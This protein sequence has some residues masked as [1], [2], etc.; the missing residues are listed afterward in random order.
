MTGAAPLLQVRGLARRYGAQSVFENVHLEVH[1]GEFVAI[2]G[3]SGVG[4]ST[5]LNCLAGLDRWDAGQGH[6]LQL[7]AAELLRQPFRQA[8]QPHGGQHGL[9]ARGVVASQQHQRQR[10]VLR[11]VQVRQ[12]MEGL[13]DEAHLRAPPQGALGIVQRAEV[14]AAVH[15]APGIP[16]VQP[17]HAVEQGGLAHA[18]VAHDG[19]KLAG[20]HGEVHILEHRGLAIALGQAVDHQRGHGVRPSSR[21]STACTRLATAWG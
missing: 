14:G 8:V 21:C 4:K 10:H 2:V 20:R 17:G 16:V 13:E 19:D 11:H 5:L 15:D 9:H 18:R 6:A 7:P 12:H 1:A 3:D